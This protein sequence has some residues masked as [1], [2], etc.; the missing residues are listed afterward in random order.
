MT[1]SLEQLWMVYSW[2]RNSGAVLNVPSMNQVGE[3]ANSSMFSSVAKFHQLSPDT[4]QGCQSECLVDMAVDFLCVDAVDEG[5]CE[6]D[7]QQALQLKPD[8]L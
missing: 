2:K 7:E 5:L 6:Y 8:H 4:H 3:W 1:R